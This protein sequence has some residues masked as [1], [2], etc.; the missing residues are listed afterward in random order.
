MVE[1]LDVRHGMSIYDPATGFGRILYGIFTNNP[2][3]ELEYAGLETDPYKHRIGKIALILLG[4]NAVN[5]KQGDPLIRPE[6]YSLLS[7]S[8]YDRVIIDRH[9]AKGF[10]LIESR[11]GI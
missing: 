3:E 11:P 7:N 9:P 6:D 2:R 1:L 8:Q 4:L 5:L 10:S